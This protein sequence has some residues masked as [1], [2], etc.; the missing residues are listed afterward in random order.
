MSETGN[1][2]KIPVIRTFDVDENG[3]AY[4]VKDEPIFNFK[5]VLFDCGR[6]QAYQHSLQNR[7]S[8]GIYITNMH[9]S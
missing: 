5:D 9:L 4:P 6:W 8:S 1:R 3:E 2:V 7:N